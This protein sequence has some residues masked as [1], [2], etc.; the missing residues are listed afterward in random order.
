[1]H[2]LAASVRNGWET[3]W[4][5]EEATSSTP[6]SGGFSYRDYVFSLVGQIRL[7]ASF[8]WLPPVPQCLCHGLVPFS[9]CF[10]VFLL[11]LISELPSGLFG[12][13]AIP[14]PE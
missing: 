11:L 3:G 2:Q 8:G 7:G 14:L 13:S 1:M 4:R 5:E 12:F 6:A 10:C 9:L